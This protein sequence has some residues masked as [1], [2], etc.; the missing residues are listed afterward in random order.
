MTGSRRLACLCRANPPQRLRYAGYRAR[1]SRKTGKAMAAAPGPSGRARERGQCKQPL[2][3]FGGALTPSQSMRGP[4]DDG[5][6]LAAST[7]CHEAHD[8]PCPMLKLGDPFSRD[9][10]VRDR[11]RCEGA[12]SFANVTLGVPADAR[13]IREVPG[14]SQVR[15]SRVTLTTLVTSS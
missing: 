6:C 13:E 8:W 4:I 14:V 12:S 7:S 10:A 3:I 1:S 2:D 9:V 15:G 5:L 11:W